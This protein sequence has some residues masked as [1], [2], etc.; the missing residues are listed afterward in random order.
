MRTCEE[1][2]FEGLSFRNCGY[3]T[4][5]EILICDLLDEPVKEHLINNSDLCTYNHPDDS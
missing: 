5:T 2:M 3:H 4:K 1:E